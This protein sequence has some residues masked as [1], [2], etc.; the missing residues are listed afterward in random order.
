MNIDPARKVVRVQYWI[1]HDPAHT[2]DCNSSCQDGR[3]C[4]FISEAFLIRGVSKN[5]QGGHSGKTYN[6]LLHPKFEK[7]IINP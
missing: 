6:K 4:Q 3:A 1:L 7:L 2:L 5:F